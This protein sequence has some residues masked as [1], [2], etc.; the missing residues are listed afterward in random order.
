MPYRDTLPGMMQMDTFRIPAPLVPNPAP[1]VPNP[2]PTP[3]FFPAS[4]LTNEYQASLIMFLD[5]N[6]GLGCS[7]KLLFQGYDQRA[8][9]VLEAIHIF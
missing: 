5:H 6:L 1:L 2:V 7:A 3:L 9:I 4:G 8:S